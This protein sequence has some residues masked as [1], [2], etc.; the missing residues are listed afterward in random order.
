[1]QPF[2]PRL[3]VSLCVF[4]SAYVCLVHAPYSWPLITQSILIQSASFS[5]DCHTLAAAMVTCRGR[6]ESA[7]VRDGYVVL[8]LIAVTFTHTLSHTWILHFNPRVSLPRSR[9]FKVM[10]VFENLNGTGNSRVLSFTCQLQRFKCRVNDWA[11]DDKFIECDRN[12]QRTH[13]TDKAANM[14]TVS[15]TAVQVKKKEKRKVCKNHLS[16]NESCFSG[17]GLQSK[18]T[19][20]TT[21]AKLTNTRFPWEVKRLACALWFCFWHATLCCFSF[22]LE[23]F[24]LYVKKKNQTDALYSSGSCCIYCYVQIQPLTPEAAACIFSHLLKQTYDLGLS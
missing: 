10:T 18:I 11:N 15:H 17:T 9:F 6:R 12:W 20:I 16:G 3:W 23:H 13:R 21:G 14:S 7:G 24:L 8:A 4:K 5:H 2:Y 22:F 1:M 19:L